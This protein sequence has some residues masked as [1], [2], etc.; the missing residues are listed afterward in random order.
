VLE[1]YVQ[2][3]KQL[4]ERTPDIFFAPAPFALALRVTTVALTLVVTEVVWAALEVV[5]VVAT[6]APAAAAIGAGVAAEGFA[7]VANLLAGLVGGFPEEAAPT[8]VTALR[9][10]AQ[11]WPQQLLAW[12]PQGVQALPASAAPL[13][14]KSQF[15]AEVN[16]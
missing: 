4:A 5:R 3:L 11:R 15:V 7:L 2:L 6:P 14:A 10:L 16:R 9:A 8:V 12:L 1:D 13:Q